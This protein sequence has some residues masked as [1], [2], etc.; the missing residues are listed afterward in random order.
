MFI[1]ELWYEA[2]IKSLVVFSCLSP[3]GHYMLALLSGVGS[4]ESVQL[5]I[6][7]LTDDDWKGSNDERTGLFENSLTDYGNVEL[8]LVPGTGGMLVKDCS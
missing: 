5:W 7:S 8:L 3:F 4:S 6:D 2:N 1:S